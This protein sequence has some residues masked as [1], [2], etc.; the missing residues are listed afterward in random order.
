[1]WSRQQ[2]NAPHAR[3]K[4][5]THCSN[6]IYSDTRAVAACFGFKFNLNL[7]R[8]NDGPDSADTQK[9]TLLAEDI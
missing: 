7:T 9:V 8:M 6:S 3:G 1:M 2:L 4:T 5:E